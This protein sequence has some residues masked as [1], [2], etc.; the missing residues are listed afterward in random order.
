MPHIFNAFKG[1]SGGCFEEN[2][3][4]H[5]PVRIVLRNDIVG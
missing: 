1:Q 2:I 3:M 5:A 4:Q